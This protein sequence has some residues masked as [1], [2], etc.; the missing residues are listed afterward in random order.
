VRATLTER[1]K[2]IGRGLFDVFPDYADGPQPTGAGNLR[3]SPS[4]A[5][6]WSNAATSAR[7]ATEH[8]MRGEPFRGRTPRD[9]VQR[10]C[11]LLHS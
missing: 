11:A 1:A 10:L 9:Y 4:T 8:A 3:A 6:F 7:K 2:T 5:P